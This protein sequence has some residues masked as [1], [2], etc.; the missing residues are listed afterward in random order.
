M[1]EPERGRH[2][3]DSVRGESLQGGWA[4][5]SSRRFRFVAL[6]GV[7]FLF[8][9]EMMEEEKV[10]LASWFFGGRGLADQSRD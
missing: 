7:R 3:E 2:F 6:L 10:G 4:R 1:P 9:T 8:A 5:A